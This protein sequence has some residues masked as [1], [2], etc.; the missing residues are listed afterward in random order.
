VRK[1]NFL[2]TLLRWM[3]PIGISAIAISLVLGQIRLPTL[4]ENLRRIRWETIML[5]I[6]LYLVSYVF[7]VLSW[8]LLL[9]RKVSFKN[10]FFTMGTGYLLNNI[11]PFRLGE[12]GRAVLLGDPKGPSTLEV[13]SSIVVERVLDVLLGSFFI[14][15]MMPRVISGDFNET[16]IL[17]AFILTLVV[18]GILFIAARFRDRINRWLLHRGENVHFIKHWLSPKIKKLLGGFSV[19]DNLPLFLLAFGSLAVSWLVAFAENY[20]IFKNLYPSPPFWWMMFVLSAAAFG[21]ALPSAPA[22]LGVFEGVMVAAFALVG[23]DAE[24]ALTHALVIHAI[25]FVFSNIIGVIGLRL[26][27]EAV[28]DLFNRVI[29][30]KPDIQ[31]VE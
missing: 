21:A 23:V 4:V 1:S 2:G 31:T 7:R 9:H 30:R 8:Y 28:I 13:L 11:F 24:L 26:R 19:L 22:G 16:L 5:G 20:V 29:H 27:G 6:V 15:A 17:I 10:T 3:I 25:A 18:L 12:I 14:L